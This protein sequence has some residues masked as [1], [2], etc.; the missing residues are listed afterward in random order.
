MRFKFLTAK[1][2][3]YLDFDQEFA[4][5]CNHNNLITL[6]TKSSIYVSKRLV[7]PLVPL[8]IL[9]IPENESWAHEV[10]KQKILVA[11]CAGWP[12]RGVKLKLST[13]TPR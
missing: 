5:F 9:S 3:A 13:K 8:A 4:R 1:G 6:K 12:L 11:R 2:L 10:G 7:L